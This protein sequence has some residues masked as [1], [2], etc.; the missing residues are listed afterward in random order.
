MK[1][2][3]SQKIRPLH[4]LLLVKIHENVQK[5]GEI[6]LA[7]F[8]KPELMSEGA[9]VAVG[10]GRYQLDGWFKP[11]T[12]KIGQVALWGQYCGM[13][14]EIEGEKFILIEEEKILA[15]FSKDYYDEA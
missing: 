1:L 11:T 3:K 14:L 7:P 13:K 4:D 9:V 12:I 8:L 10:P 5:K 2:S 15:V 6:I